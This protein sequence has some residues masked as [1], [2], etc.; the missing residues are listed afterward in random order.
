MKKLNK[1]QLSVMQDLIESMDRK[2]RYE[3]R[4]A[5]LKEEI[6]NFE[7]SIVDEIERRKELEKV[8]SDAQGK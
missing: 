2:T 5:E 8:I 3:R 7:H 4:I 6:K 1:E